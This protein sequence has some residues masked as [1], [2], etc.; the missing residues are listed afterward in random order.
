MFFKPN[1]T[2]E[3]LFFFQKELFFG[4]VFDQTKGLDKDVFEIFGL[5]VDYFDRKGKKRARNEI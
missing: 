2:P 1:K 5:D 3:K 4:C